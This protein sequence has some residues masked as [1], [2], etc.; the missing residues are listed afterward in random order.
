MAACKEGLW[1][2]P[3]PQQDRIANTLYSSFDERPKHLDPAQSYAANEIAITGQ[4]YEPPLQ[5][6]FLK[7]PY[8]LEPLVAE[9]MPSVVY[10]GKLG[11]VLPHDSP[12]DAIAYSV[13]EIRIQQGV[14]Y[15][16]HPA[17]AKN[18]NG[19]F[20]YLNLAQHEL[21]NVFTL[22]DFEHQGTRELIAND[23]VYEIKRLAHPRL[24]S[25]IFGLMTEY[26]VGL[27][28]FG[29]QL[30]RADQKLRKLQ[31]EDAFLDLNKYELEGV[32]VVDRY[33]YRIKIQGKYPQ[34]LYWLAMPFFAPIPPEA[35]RFYSQAGMVK[36]NLTLDWYP[37][38]TGPYMLTENNPNLQMIL[39]RNPN[40]R[41]EAYPSEGSA[42]DRENG[43]LSDA[44]R[45][46]PFV[47]KVVYSL[48][49]ENI[50][51]WNKFLQG[52][53]DASGIAS[54]SFDQAISFNGQQEAGL[55]DDMRQ[56][57]VKLSTAVG[58]TT[59]YMGFNMRDDV[60]GGD[61][62][63]ARKLRRAIAIAIDYEEQISIFRNGRGI[64][65]QGPVPPGIFGY[66]E[67]KQGIN[68]YVYDWVDGKPR[69][70]SIEEARELLA[71]AGYANGRDGKT[72]KSLVLYFD[73]SATGP[74]A[75]ASLDWLRKQF[76]KLG[77]QL[78][79]RSTDYNRFQDKIRKG[80]AQI[81]QWGWNAD[82][83][84][85]ENFLFLLYGP[86]AKVDEDGANSANYRNKEFD[87]LF[88][89]MK[90]MENSPKRQ[91]II[92]KM[93]NIAR[94]DG[95]WVWGFHPKQF[96]LYQ[97]WYGN[98]KPNLMANNTLKYK[99]IDPQLRAELR[100]QWNKPIIW[101]MVSIGVVLLLALIP[102]FVSYYK[103]SRIK[104]L[105]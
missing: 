90:N 95:P 32:E 26:I 23:F 79:I 54:D 84:D 1:N 66:Q 67:G 76:K 92:D 62:E 46:L 7:R 28:P 18:E 43:F 33:T 29:E 17:F 63:R 22:A 101:P 98:A 16:P 74:D 13:Y 96:S 53:Y 51:R 73:T 55:S 80:T 12:L 100:E 50:P 47:D 97:S 48:E 9:R 59:F 105:A 102:A 52:Y 40:F 6:H 4:I 31:G 39:E 30:K 77:I 83:P 20:H 64:P 104:G 11:N 56:K 27:K 19:E 38:G 25:P 93:V 34:F 87:R 91:K 15:Q 14:N 35:D 81:F 57:G 2:N 8:E 37:V 89:K 103:K 94:R 58:T 24:Y 85:P 42:D 49:K 21:E 78:L 86:N 36:K 72:G 45:A 99:T 75:K 68:P 10:L 65:A 60:V 71:Q 5:Y 82:Y 70:K 3:Y 88:E 44:G 41:G 61:S 69:R